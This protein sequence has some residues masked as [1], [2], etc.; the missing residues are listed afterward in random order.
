[1]GPG[2]NRNYQPLPDTT[3]WARFSA[4][5][6]DYQ[7]D[8]S[9]VGAEYDYDRLYGAV[10]LNISLS[11][12]LMSWISVNYLSG[13]A[14]VGSPTGGGDIDADGAGLTIGADWQG[15][16]AYYVVGSFSW[17]NYDI[18][19][20]S[21]KRGRL[22][23]GVNGDG[24]AMDV[25]AGRRFAFSDN[26]DLMP[27]AWLVHTRVSIDDFTDAVKFRGVVFGNGPYLWWPRVGSGKRA[28]RPAGWR[29]SVTAWFAGL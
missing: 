25:E 24:Y 10:G 17:Q 21:D 4:G 22:E 29:V 3:V 1:M 14:D 28:R 5:I 9:T 18:D 13:S 6:G 15:A 12:S 11:D 27:R 8:R 7:S 19:I 26:M 16:S 20:T 23:T 2:T